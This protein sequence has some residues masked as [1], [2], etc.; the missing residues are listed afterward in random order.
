MPTP[1][2]ETV[3]VAEEIATLLGGV[4][5]LRVHWYV[6][7]TTRPPAVVIGQPDIDYADPSASFCDAVWLFPLTIVVARNSD[8]EAQTLM[9]RL[10]L[11]IVQAL[12]T[13]V[14]GLFSVQPLIA[15]PITVTIGSQELPG[16]SLD[17]RVRA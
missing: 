6:S 3:V 2:L 11:E 14:P 9:S 17:V 1:S 15:R 10:L 13:D 8:R 5:G 16:Y 4:A 7:D 12:N